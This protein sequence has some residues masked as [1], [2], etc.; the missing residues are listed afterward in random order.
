MV[1][2]NL[3][4]GYPLDVLFG[5]EPKLPLSKREVLTVT[6]QDNMDIGHDS[7]MHQHPSMD[8]VLPNKLPT[9]FGVRT[10]IEPAYT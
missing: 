5:F 9:S 8:A 6:L 3:P 7:N 4:I 10:G 2:S 1:E